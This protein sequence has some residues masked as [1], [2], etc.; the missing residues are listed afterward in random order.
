M[1]ERTKRESARHLD[2]IYFHVPPEPMLFLA[3][4]SASFLP[5]SFLPVFLSFS[6]LSSLLLAGRYLERGFNKEALVPW[7]SCQF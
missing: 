1:N 6:L 4:P 5:A 2:S 7:P 3:G